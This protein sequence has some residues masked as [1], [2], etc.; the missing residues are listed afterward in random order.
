MIPRAA[1][2]AV[3]ALLLAA[4]GSSEPLVREA[5]RTEITIPSET[6]APRVKRTRLV[7][8]PRPVRVRIAAIG[9]DAPLIPLGLDAHRALEVPERFDVAGWWSGGYRPGESGPA[10]IAGHVDSKTGPA[11]FYRLGDLERGDAVMV[12]RRDGSTVRYVVKS[13]G[14]YA[15]TAFPTKQVYGPTSRPTLRLITCSGDFDRATGHYVDNTVVYAD[16]P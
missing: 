9:V 7:R 12:Q 14:R 11:V 5:P 2:V 10:V 3:L 13:V 1:G 16:I 8:A 4:C 6:P 15:K